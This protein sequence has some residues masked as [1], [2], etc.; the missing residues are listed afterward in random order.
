MPK[1][2]WMEAHNIISEAV[3]KNIP[4]KKEM[5]EG[6][7]VAPGGFTSSCEKK[8]NERQERK[9]KIYSSECRVTENSK[10]K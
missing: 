8:R 9:G 2:L 3:T 6:K 7:V 4:K 1:E 5:Q 10:E